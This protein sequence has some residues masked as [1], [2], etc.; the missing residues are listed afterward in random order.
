MP[1]PPQAVSGVSSVKETEL[2]K[3][4]SQATAHLWYGEPFGGWTLV[5]SLLP[6]WNY[7][8]CLE[9]CPRTTHSLFTADDIYCSY[10]ASEHTLSIPEEID[11]QLSLSSY[12]SGSTKVR[13]T[14]IIS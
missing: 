10:F 9:V 6:N 14:V 3:L 1:P 7:L 4:N 2:G 11:E 8:L 5:Y 13:N 12:H